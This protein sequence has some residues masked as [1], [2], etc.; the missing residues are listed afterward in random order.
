MFNSEN[1][2]GLTRAIIHIFLLASLAMAAPLL[3]LLARSPE[4]FL[5]KRAEAADVIVFVILVVLAVPLVFSA[6]QALVY[7]RFNNYFYHVQAAIIFLLLT[8]VLLPLLRNIM[9]NA[10]LIFVLAVLGGAGLTYLYFRFKFTDQFLLYLSPAILV[11]PAMFFLK[12][13]VQSV[14]A[15]DKITEVADIKLE[16]RNRPHIVMVVFDELPLISLLDERSEID[17]VRYPNFAAFAKKS[18]WFRNATTVSDYTI[19]AIPAMLTGQYPSLSKYEYKLPT[20]SQYPRNLFSWL[21][22][23]YLIHSHEPITRLSPVKNDPLGLGAG[24]FGRRIMTMLSDSVMV[25]LHII[26]PASIAESLPDIKSDWAFFTQ[27]D[28]APRK[29]IKGNDLRVHVRK[30]L[31]KVDQSEE[32][33]NFVDALYEPEKPTFFFMHVLFPHIPFKYLPDGRT[34]STDAQKVPGLF[35]KAYWQSSRFAVAQAWQRHLL[36]VGYLDKILGKLIEKLKETNLYDN[37]VVVLVADHGANFQ[38]NSHRRRLSYASGAHINLVPFM[39]KTPGQR[40]GVVHDH[41]VETIDLLPGIAWALDA[42]IPWKVDGRV[43]F[44]PGRSRQKRTYSF[45]TI[46]QL[47]LFYFSPAFRQ[48]YQA[49]RQKISL[50]GSRTGTNQLFRLGPNQQL[51]KRNVNEFDL[52]PLKR[53]SI[54]RIEWQ[55][56]DNVDR[57]SDFIPLHVRGR[58]FSS[59]KFHPL[60]LA[61][62]VNGKIAAVG[63]TILP[64]TEQNH[65]LVSMLL[66]PDSL[67][68]G[69]ND[70]RIYITKMKEGKRVLFYDAKHE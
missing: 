32:L 50:F 19:T 40:R 46:D 6:V 13:P 14:M 47:G 44:K 49:L 29:A 48:R 25:Y 35:G 61:V 7:Y 67:R 20:L 58:V 5:I 53:S 22:N 16:A 52:R 18:N 30:E 70:V 54:E 56:F 45:Y 2:P 55:V 38:I 17:S 41:S 12:A 63:E 65:G 31:N 59:Y 57:D 64:E 10:G 42:P 9:G 3:D 21:K 68:D 8:L 1:Q 51:L 39:M 33:I 27:K 34:Y 15:G 62:S 23:D 60:D 28:R 66:P 24:S 26:L 36:Q 4:F 43:P 37:S 11:F 69:K